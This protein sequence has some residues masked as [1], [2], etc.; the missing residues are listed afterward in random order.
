MIIFEV[1]RS[2]MK[3]PNAGGGGGRGGLFC[4]RHIQR[5]YQNPV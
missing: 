4:V 1:S 3:S 5:G 2:S